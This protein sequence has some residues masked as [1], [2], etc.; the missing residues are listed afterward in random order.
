MDKKK[1]NAEKRAYQKK[2]AT[3]E[4]K[5]MNARNEIDMVRVF[6]EM[7]EILMEEVANWQ[8][9]IIEKSTN[10]QI[11]DEDVKKNID[12]EIINLCT[13]I[14]KIDENR[15]VFIKPAIILYK[16]RLNSNQETEPLKYVTYDVEV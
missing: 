11:L 2:V 14:D 16:A 1:F 6:N 13:T 7:E 8:S 5:L 4:G 3:F 15:K 9:I 10:G 12:A